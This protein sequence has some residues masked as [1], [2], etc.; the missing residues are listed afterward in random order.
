MEK[1]SSGAYSAYLPELPGCIST[2]DT[3]S[4]IKNQKA[5]LIF[6]SAKQKTGILEL[7]NILTQLANKGALSNNETIVSNSRHFEAL[8]NAYNSIKEVQKGKKVGIIDLTRG[9]LG[10]RGTAER[11]DKETK[12]AT[13]IMGVSIRKNMNF[14]DGFFKDDEEHKLA[15]IKK[16]REFKK[17]IYWGCK[18]RWQI[19]QRRTIRTTKTISS[20]TS[21][22]R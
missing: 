9:E 2:G 13:D 10:T 5:E 11:R 7:T 3:I 17:K 19:T 22:N 14:K 16:I 21:R 18:D 12:K 15:L 20:K 6:L 4:D 1:T 8:N